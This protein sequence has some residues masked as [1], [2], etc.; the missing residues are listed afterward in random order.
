MKKLP[1]YVLAFRRWRAASTAQR[2]VIIAEQAQVGT[3]IEGPD[4]T[5]ATKPDDVINAIMPNG[6]P[7]A[8]CTRT[9]FLEFAEWRGALAAAF[10]ELK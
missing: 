2:M 10:A 1:K 6:K 4:L 3:G 9:D 7:L 5:K 8:D